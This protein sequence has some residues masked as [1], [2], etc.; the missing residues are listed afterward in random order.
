MSDKCDAIV[1]LEGLVDFEKERVRI[2][3]V[4]E[5]KQQQLSKLEEAMAVPTYVDKVPV[6]VQ[7]ANKEKEA[8]INEE[9]IKLTDALKALSTLY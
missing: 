5:K 4:I 8:E 6:A 9:L 1:N 2:T 3:S 7:V